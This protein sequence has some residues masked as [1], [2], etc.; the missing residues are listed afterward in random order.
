MPFGDGETVSPAFAKPTRM[1]VIQRK[2]IELLMAKTSFKL[3]LFITI[4]KGIG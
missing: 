1:S 2:M 4:A 3:G